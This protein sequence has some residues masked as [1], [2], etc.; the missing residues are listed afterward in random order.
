MNS[1]VE[2]FFSSKS[3]YN[4]RSCAGVILRFVLSERSSLGFVCGFVVVSGS[5][6]FALG[7]CSG[8]P[9]EEDYVGL[10]FGIGRIAIWLGYG[11]DGLTGRLF[12]RSAG[13]LGACV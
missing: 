2:I 10:H 4:I 3:G 11:V 13:V 12:A 5:I 6:R 9:T 1:L 8:S 7:L